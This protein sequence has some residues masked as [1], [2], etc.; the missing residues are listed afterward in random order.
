MK[1]M[2]SKSE[3]LEH[4]NEQLEFLKASA[5]SF[6]NGFLGEA[7]R[8]VVTIRVLLHDAQNSKSLLGLLKMKKGLFF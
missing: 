4:L 6:D 3:L 5:L 2:Q 7:K 1:V 8:L